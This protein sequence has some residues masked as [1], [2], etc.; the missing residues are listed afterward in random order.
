MKL[1]WLSS[2]KVQNDLQVQWFESMRRMVINSGCSTKW[3]ILM[4][5]GMYF[6]AVAQAELAIYPGPQIVVISFLHPKGTKILIE[7]VQP[8]E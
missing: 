5:Y 3:K 8:A 6:S 2:S 7:L 4:K 1:N